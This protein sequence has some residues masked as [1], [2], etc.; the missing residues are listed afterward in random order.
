[1]SK[2]KS[3]KQTGSAESKPML[4]TPFSDAI[5]KPGGGAASPKPAQAKSCKS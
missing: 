5:V 2:V 3:V 1:M 4:K